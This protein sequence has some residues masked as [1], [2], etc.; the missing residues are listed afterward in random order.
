MQNNLKDLSYALGMNVAQSLK[1]QQFTEIDL[2]SFTEA[3]DAILKGNELRMDDEQANKSIQVY[4]QEKQKERFTKNLEEGTVFLAQN[5][6]REVVKTTES[7][8][9]YEVLTEGAG[10][11]PV[12]HSQVTVHYHGTLING[13]VFDSSYQRGTPATFGL[14]QVIRGWTEGLQL[15][16]KGSKFR[17]YIPQE[18]A[19]G[20][21]PRPGGP[22]EPYSALIFDVELLEIQ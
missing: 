7:G 1:S 2:E 14:N 5:G 15:M 18:L 10:E 9:Q 22:I 12:E 16:N 13:E 21:S 17:F 19:Y 6:Q 4:L 20:A 3:F 8:L 11:N